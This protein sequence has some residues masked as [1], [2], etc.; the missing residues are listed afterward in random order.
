MNEPEYDFW[1]IS[2]IAFLTTAP[3]QQTAATR[4]YLYGGLMYI[5]LD[6]VI[7]DIEIVCFVRPTVQNSKILNLQ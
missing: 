2:I 5:F 1:S 4:D 6:Y 3:P 7:Q